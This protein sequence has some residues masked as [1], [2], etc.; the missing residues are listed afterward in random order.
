MTGAAGSGV[1][2]PPAGNRDRKYPEFPG[3][4]ARIITIKAKQRHFKHSRAES[5][6][7][8]YRI[9]DSASKRRK[10]QLRVTPMHT[11]KMRAKP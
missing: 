8:K 10:V 1:A 2:R 9:R 6:Q 4:G 3:Y 11:F 5:T 7:D